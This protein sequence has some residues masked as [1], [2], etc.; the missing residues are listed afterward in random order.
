MRAAPPQILQVGCDGGLSRGQTRGDWRQLGDEIRRKGGRIIGP[1]G[2]LKRCL[3]AR[4]ITAF[5]LRDGVFSPRLAVRFVEISVFTS[6]ANDTS[7]SASASTESFA[8]T[9]A[10]MEKLGGMQN[11]SA[12]IHQ[13]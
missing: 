2:G 5:D 6:A 11:F 7:R 13:S 1:E 3:R 4:G 8:A 9:P 10:L 12:N